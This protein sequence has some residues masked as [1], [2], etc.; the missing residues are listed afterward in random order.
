[1]FDDNYDEHDM[2]VTPLEYIRIGEQVL[3]FV[4]RTMRNFGIMDESKE[5]AIKNMKMFEDQL[6]EALNQRFYEPLLGPLYEKGIIDR[7]PYGWL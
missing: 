6:R 4:V 2:I 3:F 7:G 1:M 5:S